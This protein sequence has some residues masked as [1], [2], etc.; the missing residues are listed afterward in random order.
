MTYQLLSTEPRSRVG[1]EANDV[2]A[3]NVRGEREPSFTRVQFGEN[4]LLLGILHFHVHANARCRGQVCI[5]GCIEQF[6]F[7][8]AN[9]ECLIGYFLDEAFTFRFTYVKVERVRREQQL[10]GNEDD[11]EVKL[12]SH[13]SISKTTTCCF[14]PE[15]KE[16]TPMSMMIKN[17]TSR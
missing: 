9:H 8:L 14:S 4:D 12:I 2:L 15:T 16:K 7:V 1:I 6:H 10:K 11:T 13:V 3:R 17:N 5:R